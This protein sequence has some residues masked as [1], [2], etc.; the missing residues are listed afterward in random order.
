[1]YFPNPAESIQIW[2]NVIFI[3][4]FQ[5][6]NFVKEIVKKKQFGSVHVSSCNLIVNFSLAQFYIY[7]YFKIYYLN[8]FLI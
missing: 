1:M 7:I 8:L 4:Y 2:F 6:N 3:I 5:K